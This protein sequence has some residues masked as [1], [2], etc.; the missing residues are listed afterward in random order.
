MVATR[1]VMEKFFSEKDLR[2]LDDKM[3]D[4]H[5]RKK[6]DLKRKESEGKINGEKDVST[7][8]TQLA[9]RDEEDTLEDEEAI[10]IKVIKPSPHGSSTQLNNEETPLLDK[11]KADTA[12]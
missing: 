4:F 5:L 8:R 12:V 2:Y 3:P 9:E 7:T 6:E 11:T 10:M 1:K